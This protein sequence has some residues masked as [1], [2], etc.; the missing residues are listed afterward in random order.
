MSPHSIHLPTSKQCD[1]LTVIRAIIS[2][3]EFEGPW[4]DASAERLL[5]IERKFCTKSQNT[6]SQL[7]LHHVKTHKVEELYPSSNLQSAFWIEGMIDT[8]VVFES[9]EFDSV[10]VHVVSLHDDSHEE[11]SFVRGGN[12]S[13]GARGLGAVATLDHKAITVFSAPVSRPA[14]G[15]VNLHPES[16]G[17]EYTSMPVRTEGSWITSQRTSLFCAEIEFPE[18]GSQ[19]RLMNGWFDTLQGLNDQEYRPFG[20]IHLNKHGLSLIIGAHVPTITEIPLTNVYY[21]PTQAILQQ[22]HLICKKLQPAGFY[23]ASYSPRVSP[24]GNKMVF[25]QKRNSWLEDEASLI[26]VCENLQSTPTFSSYEIYRDEAR[27]ILLSPQKVELSADGT[28]FYFLAEDRAEM[29]LFYASPSTETRLVAQPLTSGWSIASFHLLDSAILLSGS[30]MTLPRHW[31]TLSIPDL[32]LS[33]ICKGAAESDQLE[34]DRVQFESI[35]W[36][37]ADDMPVQAWIIKPR[38]FQPTKRYPLLYC[39]HG[40]PNAGFTN[41][42]ASSYWANW[43]FALFAEQGYVV[44]APNFSGSTG[45]GQEYARRVINE[46]GGKPYVDLEKGFDYIEAHLPFVDTTRAVALGIS[47]GGYMVNWIQGQPLGRRFKALVTESG[48]LNTAGLYV[49]PQTSN[50]SSSAC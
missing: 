40:G 47:Y 36:P 1:D 49:S 18:S 26:V 37:G 11:I 20:G 24:D 27:K 2:I 10:D 5:Y 21:V 23:G 9:T 7:K 14:T 38:N 41:A 15:R 50:Y 43:N 44:V 22:N 19:P 25:L 12:L 29:R 34:L 4:P 17:R 42:W 39:I 3:P 35:E 48:L 28:G 33:T 45:F 32:V 13:N 31:A 6:T 30:T 8:I 16:S 46:H